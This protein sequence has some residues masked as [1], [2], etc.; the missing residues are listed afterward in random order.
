MLWRGPIAF[1]CSDNWSTPV[2]YSSLIGWARTMVRCWTLPPLDGPTLRELIP[3]SVWQLTWKGY[4]CKRFN[5]VIGAFRIIYFSSLLTL[6]FLDVFA[7]VRISINCFSVRSQTKTFKKIL[8]NVPGNL[9]NKKWLFLIKDNAETP[10]CQI[11]M[12]SSFSGYER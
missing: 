4:V 5:R 6:W 2:C 10:F 12:L 9:N 11:R 1:C 3:I 7:M 8:F